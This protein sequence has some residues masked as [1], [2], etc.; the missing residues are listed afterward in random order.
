MIS[1]DWSYSTVIRRQIWISGIDLYIFTEGTQSNQV[2]SHFEY[3][4]MH[5]DW[6]TI[7]NDKETVLLFLYFIPVHS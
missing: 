1:G 2:G 4:G 3:Y 5:T 7:I 6:L